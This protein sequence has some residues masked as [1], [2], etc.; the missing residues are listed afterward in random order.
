MSENFG[1]GFSTGLNEPDL[2]TETEVTAACRSKIP[3]ALERVGLA[4]FKPTTIEA[5][6]AAIRESLAAG[7][8]GECR[9]GLLLVWMLEMSDKKVSIF[10]E[11]SKKTFNIAVRQIYTYLAGGRLLLSPEFANLP[12]ELKK[13]LICDSQ[14]LEML[15]PVAKK[16]AGTLRFFLEH[17]DPRAMTREELA[18]KV[19]LYMTKLLSEADRAAAAKAVQG[20]AEAKAVTSIR[21]ALKPLG[22]VEDTAMKAAVQRVGPARC[23]DAGLRLMAAAVDAQMDAGPVDPATVD[24]WKTLLRDCLEELEPKSQ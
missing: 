10:V 23:F 5:A 13:L 11:E 14:K 9:I 17:N 1:K 15:A 7:V 21:H 18:E 6:D 22:A 12:E 16:S 20:S 19:H 3:V 24:G 8:R 2:S 4:V